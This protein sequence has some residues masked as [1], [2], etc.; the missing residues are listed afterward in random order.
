V[1][2]VAESSIIGTVAVESGATRAV[3]GISDLCHCL[4]HADCN[5]TQ[6]LKY[7]DEGW[8]IR[9]KVVL[10]DEGRTSLSRPYLPAESEMSVL[11]IQNDSSTHCS[12]TA[13]P[14]MHEDFCAEV[15]T[16][17]T[18]LIDRAHNHEPHS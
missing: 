14:A 1:R 17:C 4:A 9:L 16:A 3:D 13:Q 5:I 10:A 8:C 2:D 6:L 15:A 11:G 7:V 18:I 12:V